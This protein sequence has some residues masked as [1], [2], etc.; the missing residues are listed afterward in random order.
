MKV[1]QITMKLMIAI[2]TEE[3]NWGKYS[4]TDNPCHN[5]EQIIL[6]QELFDSFNIIPT[7]LLTYPVVKDGQSQKI[8]RHLL[9]EGRCEIG[10]HCHPWNTPPFEEELCTKNT[11]LTNLPYELILKK[12]TNL[13]KTIIETFGITPVSFRAGRFAFNNDV[14]KALITLG[15]KIDL[16]ITPYEDQ[17]PYFGPDFTNCTPKPYT[18]S[19]DNIFSP[20]SDGRLVEFPLSTGFLQGNFNLTNSLYKFLHTKFMKRLKIAGILGRLNMLNMACLCPETCSEKKMISIAKIFMK[21]RFSV[22]NMMFHSTS[23]SAGYSP[24][25]KTKIE[26]ERIFNRIKVFLQFA[27]DCGIEFI[28]VSDSTDVV[29][30]V[31]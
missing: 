15:Y 17:R 1:I 27:R 20:R 11:M 30:S 25:A 21:K 16:S 14:A 24:F 29:R 2:D 18:L 5:I 12:I 22:V 3:D 10:T 28:K 23:L 31:K 7:Y 8:L 19:E 6:L 13:H 4:R 26:E 9:S